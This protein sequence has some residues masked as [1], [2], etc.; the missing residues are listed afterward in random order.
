MNKRILGIFVTVLALAMFAVPVM[1]KPTETE[2]TYI[3]QWTM[4]MIY[5]K[6]V[7]CGESGNS[8][9]KSYVEG[10]IINLA[11]MQH[12][13]DYVQEGKVTTNGKTLIMEWHF[14]Q[15]WTKV[16]DPDSGFKG[17][18]NGKGSYLP[19]NMPPYTFDVSGVLN[20]FGELNGQKLIV[21]VG[22]ATGW[23][24]KGILVTK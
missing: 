15:L 4:D 11:T 14:K 10:E 8:L 1:A 13:F 19:G 2:V 7:L 3:G 17:T 16:G 20:G 21:E 24:I 18:L 22:A 23:T 6:I 12:E 9:V 5:P